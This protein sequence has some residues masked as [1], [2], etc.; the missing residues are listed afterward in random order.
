MK[1]RLPVFDRDDCRRR[2][3]S[4]YNNRAVLLHELIDFLE[5][6]AKRDSC[7]FYE[8]GHLLQRR[9]Y[10]LNNWRRHHAQGNAHVLHLVVEFG[11]YRSIFL[12]V[13]AQFFLRLGGR[14]DLLPSFPEQANCPWIKA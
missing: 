10:Q 5:L 1:N 14:L 4:H 6:L 11:S 8:V 13:H 3:Y 2:S 7:L 9:Q 12:G